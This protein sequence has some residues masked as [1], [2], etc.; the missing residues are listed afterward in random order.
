MAESRIAAT[1][2]DGV[3]VVELRGITRTYRGRGGA[4][5]DAVRD[6][7]LSVEAGEIFGLVGRSGAGKSTI[8]RLIL[9]LERPDSGE[10]FFEGRSLAEL[11]RADLKLVRRR[12]QLLQ[13][14]PFD[15]LHPGMRLAAAVAEPLVIAGVARAVRTQRAADALESVGLTPAERFLSR[16]PDELSGGQRQRVAIAR[17]LVARPRLLVADEPTSMLDASLR[18]GILDLISALRD[19]LGTAVLFITHDLA[20]ARHVCDRI[21]VVDGG[22]LVEVGAPDALIDSPQH[23][24][25]EQLLAAAEPISTTGEKH[26]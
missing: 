21:G 12:M 7:S 5:I 23:P 8:G 11:S 15:A 13:Q 16:Y 26:D 10:M 2:A 9:G 22:R 3:P 14:D 17:A 6:V 18:A 20:L 1:V 19:S 4:P 24:A 25:T